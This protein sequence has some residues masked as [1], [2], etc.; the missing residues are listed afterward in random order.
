MGVRPEG[1]AR[2]CPLRARGERLRV[3][4]RRWMLD[5]APLI[6]GLAA[7]TVI[8]AGLFARQGDGVRAAGAARAPGRLTAA[9]R[10]RQMRAPAP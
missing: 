8:G 3:A 2:T 10:R 5:G 6:G 9:G 7:T 4:A 1:F